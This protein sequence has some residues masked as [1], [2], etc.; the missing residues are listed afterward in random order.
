MNLT[1]DGE[2]FILNSKIFVLA[3]GGIENSRLL[4]NIGRYNKRL[5]SDMPV[6]KYWMEHPF[7][8]IGSGVG[9]FGKIKKFF[10]N[11][12]H[13]F[14]NFMNY[15]NFTVSLSPT[16]KYMASEKILNLVYFYR[17]TSAIM[18]LLKNITKNL[19]CHAPKIS[20]K[21]IDMFDR[22]LLC[23]ITISSSW[24]QEPTI[25]NKIELSDDFDFLGMPKIKLNY[26]LSKKNNIYCY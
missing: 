7:K 9:N 14:E 4:L 12:F 8:I 21:I 24:E 3:S 16:K 18:I 5:I 6:G 15:G 25:N 10:S 20:K 1:Y 2:N 11:D 22:E 19:L 23:G 26:S 13:Y 17:C